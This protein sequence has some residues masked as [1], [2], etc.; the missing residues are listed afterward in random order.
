VL[1]FV[2]SRLS[3]THGVA[4]LALMLAL[5]GGAYAAGRFVIT[6]T[7]QISPKVLKALKG[8]PGPRG[9]SGAAGASGTTGPGGPQGPAGPAGAP[10][11]PGEKGAQGVPGERG[12]EGPPGSPWSVGG[13]LP[14]GKS[15]KGAWA[16]G[17]IAAEALP[18][19]EIQ[20]ATASFTIPLKA[21]LSAS[22]VHY[23]DPAGKEVV[24][25]EEELKEKT[26]TACTGSVSDPVAEAGNLCVYAAEETGA[27]SF[28]GFISNPAAAGT[29]PE[30]G[31]GT[32]GAVLFVQRTGS[33]VRL[34]GTWAVTAP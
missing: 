32:T 9:A 30:E 17:P 16:F 3:W 26:S 34:R 27:V 24:F 28:D 13:T 18:S 31:A 1:S 33:E 19:S 14:S 21:A 10:G 4:V 15:E 20:V 7:K 25:E 2:R 6:S 23:I 5:S 22:E 12:E 11:K 8:K 29:A